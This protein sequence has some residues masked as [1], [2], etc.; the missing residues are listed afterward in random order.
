MTATITTTKNKTALV[1]TF[2]AEHSNFV[3]V[4]VEYDVTHEPRW[5]SSVDLL[6]VQ[7]TPSHVVTVTY[8][9][10]QPYVVYVATPDEVE[11]MH[12]P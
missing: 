11:E 7:S 8:V 12:W 1:K 4:E 5:I 10:L 2:P 9:S 3:L 6:P